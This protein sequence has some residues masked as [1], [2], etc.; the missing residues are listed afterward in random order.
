[1]TN[2]ETSGKPTNTTQNQSA[3]Q[4]RVA[5]A[6]STASE[7]SWLEPKQKSRQFGPRLRKL[8]ALLLPAVFLVLLALILFRPFQHPRTHLFTLADSQTNPAETGKSLYVPIQPFLV[9]DLRAFES[10]TPLLYQDDSRQGPV[11]I[12]SVQQAGIHT[13]G[14]V[15]SQQ[16]IGP[17]D[18]LLLYIRALGYTEADQGFMVWTLEPERLSLG[19]FRLRDLLSQLAEFR[20]AEKILLLDAGDLTHDPRLGVVVNAFPE[21]LKR[22]VENTGD[23]HLWVFSSHQILEKSHA[24]LAKAQTLFGMYVANGLRGEAD[25]NSDRTVDL[26]ELHRFVSA[27]V[28]MHVREKSDGNA[29]QTPELL[30]GGGHA[31][32]RIK[33]GKW[34]VLV[35]VVESVLKPPTA[36]K[37]E[38]EAKT[39]SRKATF[40]K[41]ARLSP[42]RPMTPSLSS[43]VSRLTPTTPALPVLPPVVTR[44]VPSPPSASTLIEQTARNQIAQATTAKEAPKEPPA[45]ESPMAATTPAETAPVPSPPNATGSPAKEPEPLPQTIPELFSKVWELRDRLSAHDSPKP[46]PLD[47]APHLWRAFEEQMLAYERIYLA[48]EIADPAAITSALGGWIRALE[49]L[50]GGSAELPAGAPDLVQRM[51]AL[52]PQNPLPDERVFS[53]GMVELRGRL[54]GTPLPKGMGLVMQT[55]EGFTTKGTPAEFA[56]WLNPLPET[57][58]QYLEIRLA[59]RL[60]DFSDR[61]WPLVQ[62][63]LKTAIRAEQ[64]PI[65]EVW[66]HVWID[67]RLARADRLRWEGERELLDQASRGWRQRASELLQ[68][69]L[70]E[71]EAASEDVQIVRAARMLQNDVLHRLPYYVRWWHAAGD[72]SGP[73]SVA[74]GATQLASLMELVSRQSELLENPA[75][76]HVAEIARIQHQIEQLQRQIEAPLQQEFVAGLVNGTAANGDE[77]RIRVL[78]QTPL[79]N[80]ETRMQLLGALW[81]VDEQLESRL[82]HIHI[83]EKLSTGKEGLTSA[84][85][86][87]LARRS[88]L[89]VRLAELAALHPEDDAGAA[90]RVRTAFD[91]L[92]QISPEEGEKLFPAYGDLGAVLRDFYSTLPGR[93]GAAYRQNE[94]LSDEARRVTCLYALRAT[95]RSLRLLDAR[96][97]A[98]MVDVDPVGLLRRAEAADLLAWQYDRMNQTRHDADPVEAQYLLTTAQ[99]YRNEL[100][101][102]PRTAPP[103]ILPSPLELNVEPELSVPT[104]GV[105]EIAVELTWKGLNPTQVWLV[106]KYDS[107]LMNVMGN[108]EIPTYQE[109][110]LRSLGL[111]YPFRPPA[112]EMPRTAILNPGESTRL[113]FRIQAKAQAEDPARLIFKA[114]TLDHYIREQTLVTL[115]FPELFQVE[116]GGTPGSWSSTSEGIMLYPFPNQETSFQLRLSFGDDKPRLADAELFALDQPSTFRLPRVALSADAAALW[117]GRLGPRTSLAAAAKIAVPANGLPVEIPFPAETAKPETPAPMPMPAPAPMNGDAA[118]MEEK[119]PEN[120]PQTVPIPHDLLMI[121]TDAASGRK[122]LKRIQLAPQRPR[123]YL[124][125]QVGY[126]LDR[127]RIEI[128]VEM[129]DPDSFSPN[130]VRIAAELAEGLQPGWTAQLAGRLNTP[131]DVARLFVNVPELAGRVVTLRLHADGYPRAFVFHVAC[132]ADSDDL[133]EETSLSE[134]RIIS[135]ADGSAYPV[136][137]E[138]VPVEFQVDAPLGAFQTRED[139]VQVGIDKDRDRTFLGDAPLQFRSDRQV[140]N[141]W[142]KAGAG[143]WITLVSAVSDFQVDVPT[144]GL[145]NAEVNLL[146]NLVTP[147][148]TDWSLPRKLVF[149]GVGPR[150]L[151]PE[152]K[153]G[154]ATIGNVV[155]QGKDA[156]VSVR[157]G[158]FAKSGVV[159][160]LAA[161]DLAGEGKFGTEPPPIPAKLTEND[162]WTAVLGTGELKPGIYEVLFQG[163]D[164]VGNKGDY[165][166]TKIEIISPEDAEAR[167]TQ[168]TNVLTGVILDGKTPAPKIKV[169]LTQKLT[170]EEQ[171]KLEAEKKKPLII[172]STVTDDEGKF[173]FPK[174]QIGDYTLTIEGIT[175]GLRR[176]QEAAITIPPPPTRLKPL[177]MRIDKPPAP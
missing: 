20:A 177:E 130:G 5:D 52:L 175:R 113:R 63:A 121:V 44:T 169:T 76:E 40:E 101:G 146:A 55:L 129:Q 47:Y 24:S 138:R 38:E 7:P 166:S 172:P 134:V 104:E 126:N 88:E 141:G 60:R 100:S 107:D 33:D 67:E 112:D 85:W 124:R 123:R 116:L 61:D 139:L 39:P 173:V 27:S 46:R 115:P 132:D 45:T 29:S 128:Q 72:F 54:A 125:A 1:M 97:V 96:D 147:A 155:T 80:R 89:D 77:W 161:F 164:R 51:L 25:L 70:A 2:P 153:S 143:G 9:E 79:P 140:K 131:N 117:L 10:L 28:Q 56:S 3:T 136:P 174:V 30:W 176:K 81:S 53:L 87:R 122:I 58:Q 157:A 154:D 69:A 64:V 110:R 158:D 98:R 103:M 66:A 99:I 18:N 159:K 68:S 57:Y 111:T 86:E 32:V 171:Q 109:D 94:N 84:D 151:R 22:E 145:E 105:A 163:I 133:P 49:H 34:P 78:L 50:A 11:S 114:V 152:L 65:A 26:D 165:V 19:R 127:E 95:D 13:L 31:G 14:E 41:A 15:L 137:T 160:V 108:S 106:L 17:E 83:P 102:L 71:Y 23:P 12:G 21:W 167:K 8:L 162:R 35:P 6:A 156:E 168:R 82:S 62:L 73:S 48:G 90:K 119:P 16:N 120:A 4:G 148:R 42:S 144:W 59:Y 93:I 170:M 74:P 91:V 75:S 43:T 142:V 36:S 150:L 149:D 37:P 118:P 135:P 92:R